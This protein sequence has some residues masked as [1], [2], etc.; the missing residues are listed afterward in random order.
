M[1][2][3]CLLLDAFQIEGCASMLSRFR[4]GCHGLH[5]D[6]GRRVETKRED[7]LCQVCHSSK[8]VEDEQHFSFSCPAYSD[9]RQKHASLSQQAFSVSVFFAKS[10]PNACGC[11]LRECFSL[12]NLLYPPDISLSVFICFLCIVFCPLGPC[13]SPGHQN[14]KVKYKKAPHSDS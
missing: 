2:S 11:F 12:E 6:T 8:D 4:C 5:V 14:I 13:W 9:V 3:T 10:G 7:R 1:L